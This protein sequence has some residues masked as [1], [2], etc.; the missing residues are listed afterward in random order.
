MSNNKRTLAS[1]SYGITSPSCLLEKLK[2]EGAKLVEPPYDT[3]DVFNFL[4]TVSVLVDWICNKYYPKKKGVS[5][6]LSISNKQWTVH[7]QVEKWYSDYKS[8]PNPH[9]GVTRHIANCLSI[10]HLTAN[11]S[12]HFHWEGRE[13]VSDISD[14]P[15]IENAYDYFFTSTAPDIYV[16]FEEENYGLQQVKGILIP[17]FEELIRVV[18]MKS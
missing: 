12:K 3:D 13:A 4:I 18:E 10:C 17:F 11:A 5:T 7:Q 9:N 2:R 6:Y 16:R 14:E 15:I 1:I 8:F